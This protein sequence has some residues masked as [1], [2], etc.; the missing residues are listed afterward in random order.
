MTD[1]HGLALDTTPQMRKIQIA[2]WSKSSPLRKAEMIDALCKDVR[3]L[4]RA[5][6]HRRFPSA[7]ARE[8]TLRL[9]ALSIDR[10]LMV[11]VFGWDPEREGL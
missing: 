8:Q 7:S 9:G 1:S 3:A 2:R 5:G 11:E 10:G 4:A 6:L